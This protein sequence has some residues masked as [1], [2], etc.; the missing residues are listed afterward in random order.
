M[1]SSSPPRGMVAAEV[2]RAFWPAWPRRADDPAGHGHPFAAHPGGERGH[3]LDAVG[4]AIKSH[5]QRRHHVRELT[6]G[7]S[8]LGVEPNPRPC[9]AGLCRESPSRSSIP[10]TPQAPNLERRLLNL[11]I[12]ELP[13][14]R[15][16]DE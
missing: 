10:A 6:S 13:G 15:R 11:H 9:S 16:A 2:R 3:D 8:R 12:A 1:T 7:S 4:L 14:L 5:H